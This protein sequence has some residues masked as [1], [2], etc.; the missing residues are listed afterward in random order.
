L[1]FLAPDSPVLAHVF[2][3]LGWAILG[4]LAGAGLSLFVPNMKWTLGLVG[5]AIGGAAGAVGFIAVSSLTGDLVGRLV[6]GLVLGFCI[7]LMVAVAEAAFRR[8]WLEVRYGARE[9]ITVTLGPEPVKVGGDARACTVWARGAPP[10]A[11]RFFVRDGKVICD[12][13][14]MKRETTVGDGFV[15]EAGNVTVTVRTGGTAGAAAPPPPRPAAP[16]PAAKAAPLSLDD[17]DGFE[18]PMPA[19]SAPQPASAPP[20]SPQP[21]APAAVPP[22][23]VATPP[24]PAAPPRPPVPAPVSKP[25]MPPPA[26][27]PATPSPSP[28]AGPKHPDACPSCGRVNAGKPR[29]RYCMVC[30]QTY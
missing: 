17:D 3:V 25:A 14:V 5:G 12:D 27:K 28:P 1:F 16:P 4:G 21:V 23:P 24:K 9:T 11:L 13:A 22:K 8:A 29:Q 18:L 7:G 19:K 6:G 26:P 15:K 10:L 2:R 20:R 30:D